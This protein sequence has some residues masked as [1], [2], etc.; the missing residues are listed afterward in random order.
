MKAILID[1]EKPALMHLERM[2]QT[3]GR[4]CVTGTFTNPREGFAHLAKDKTDIVFL[5]IGMPEMN[6]LQAGEYIQQIDP[7]IRIVYITAYADYA[8]EAFEL[9]ALDYVLKPVD[10]LRFSKTIAR[11]EED[12]R[13]RSMRQAEVVNEPRVLCFKRLTLQDVASAG[14]RLKWRTQKAQELFAF[15]IHM[16]GQWVTKDAI[17][18]RLWPE[19]RQDK[20]ITHLHTSVY[21]IRR[22]LKDWG[23]VAGVEYS[24]DS[25]RIVLDGIATDVE[26]FEDGPADEPVTEESG[27]LR[28]DQLLS[29]YRGDY[30]EEHDY[31]WAKAARGELIHRF[32][33]LSLHTAVYELA[34]CRERQAIQ[35]LGRVLEKDPYSEKCCLLFLKAYASLKDYG[36]LTSHYESFV[37][38]LQKDLGIEPERETVEAYERFIQELAL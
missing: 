24:Q 25:Y 22:M 6:G 19:Y 5:D 11:I 35:R 3:D 1:D 9:N 26:Q 17:M 21:Q 38:L 4:V 18:D 13:R 10:P 2:I 30:F 16:R 23:V 31:D 12:A 8:L 27:W 32:V 29:L 36:S 34:T 14:E 20:A 15:L 7:D 33:R 28:N 37:R